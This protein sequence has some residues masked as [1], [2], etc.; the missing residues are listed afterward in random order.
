M[1]WY[2]RLYNYCINNYMEAISINAELQRRPRRHVISGYII[3]IFSST[4]KLV[5]HFGT[6]IYSQWH[7]STD[8]G[9]SVTKILDHQKKTP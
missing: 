1:F 3:D 4:G 2:D 9:P 8:T 7:K 5:T 6:H